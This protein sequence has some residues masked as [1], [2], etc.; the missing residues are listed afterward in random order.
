MDGSGAFDTS[1]TAA[2]GDDFITVFQGP[3]ASR[4]GRVAI[5]RVG[6]GLGLQK[7]KHAFQGWARSLLEI[8][9]DSGARGEPGG[10]LG[11]WIDLWTRAGPQSEVRLFV[12]AKP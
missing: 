3:G 7:Q 5:E 1:R 11:C 10:I 8:L 12:E 4:G 9:N 6:R 2:A